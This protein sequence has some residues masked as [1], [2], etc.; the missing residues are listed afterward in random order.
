MVGRPNLP[1]RRFRSLGHRGMLHILG[2]PV[3]SGPVS[4][5]RVSPTVGLANVVINTVGGY[6]DIADYVFFGHDVMLLTGTHDFR[7]L[8]R[9]RQINRQTADR[10]III[11]TGA[12]IASRAII[13]GPC[14]IGANAVVG[15]GCVV[16]FDV[17][18][19]TVVR[20]KQEVTREKISYP[21]LG[22]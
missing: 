7:Q 6:V 18:A 13:V 5:V 20:L 9:M 14:R 4:R 2:Q 8:G 11:E 17:P 12:W 21:D 22:Q 19:D 3:I 1:H 10:D 16:D 15:C